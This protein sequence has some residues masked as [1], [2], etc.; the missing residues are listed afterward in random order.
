MHI[1]IVCIH[2]YAYICI[3]IFACVCVFYMIPTTKRDDGLAHN[4]YSCFYNGDAM[5]FL[6]GTIEMLKNNS[7]KIKSSN[8]HIYIYMYT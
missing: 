5:C 4:L 3:Y 2:I 6:F 8:V 1:Y 7:S